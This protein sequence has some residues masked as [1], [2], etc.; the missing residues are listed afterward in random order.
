MGRCRTCEGP[1]NPD[2]LAAEICGAA[3]TAATL[4]FVAPTKVVFIL[5][6]GFALLTSALIDLRTQRLPDALT[7]V[8]G[9]AGAAATGLDGPDVFKVHLLVAFISFCVLMLVRTLSLA[10]KGDHGLGF[11]DVKLV[12]ALGLW[13][14]LATPWMI[15]FASGLGLIV[16]VARRAWRERL[17]FGPILALSAMILGIAMEAGFDFAG[18]LTLVR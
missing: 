4:A 9:V 12:G 1:I 3:M 11:G 10:R 7:L 5:V 2:H 15:A 14:G 13:L 18:G 17:P 8:I 16:V 6:I